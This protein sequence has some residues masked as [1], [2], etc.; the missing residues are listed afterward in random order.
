MPLRVTSIAVTSVLVVAVMLILTLQHR[1][2][3]RISQHAVI[4]TQSVMK[5]LISGAMQLGPVVGARLP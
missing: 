3:Q 5:M 2:D 1:R 4:R